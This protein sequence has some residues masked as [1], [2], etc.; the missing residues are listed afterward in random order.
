[1]N[2]LPS[3]IHLRKGIIEQDIEKVI[4]NP[5]KKL[6]LYF[7]VRNHGSVDIE[8]TKKVAFSFLR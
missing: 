5:N 4:P 7:T 3:A 1:M 2:N 8:N 6:V